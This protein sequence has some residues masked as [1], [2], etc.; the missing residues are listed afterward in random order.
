MLPVELFAAPT[1]PV[2]ELPLILD[3]A[4]APGGKTTHLVS[5][6]KDCALVLAND[7]SAGRLPALCA[8]LQ[9]WGAINAAVTC[10]PGERFGT[11][12]PETFDRVL[13]DAPCSMEHL[14][15]GE[16]QPHRPISSRERQGLA[17]R[18]LRLLVSAFQALKTGG[19]LV[20]ATCTLAPEEDEA[21]LDGLLRLYSGRVVVEDCSSHLNQ[22]APALSEYQ[23][24]TFDP[25]VQRAARLWPHLF[26]T[27]GFFTAL[28]TKTGPVD[29]NLQTPP[30][31]PFASSGFSPL[32]PREV[33]SLFGL[34]ASA[35][36]FDLESL[37]T[38]EHLSLWRRGAGVFALP[39]TFLARIPGLPWISLGL[40]MGDETPDG[41]ILSH[42]WAARFGSQFTQG[43]YSLPE[44]LLPSWLAGEDLRGLPHPESSQK[45]AYIVKDAAGRNLGRGR[46]AGD[47]LRNLL[48]KK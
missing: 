41:F 17:Q 13:L 42:A 1:P 33:S 25:S 46:F 12:F 19:Q 10:F 39:E 6:W 22:P 48:P 45:I 30:G 47:R 9:D 34:F 32:A 43:G 4:A 37:L 44:E 2:N 40:P 36:G 15:P 7:S 28:L 16:P 11:W 18:Q 14:R 35:Y 24:Q 26:N 8:A 29:V 38:E 21:V 5:R 3:L 27:S 20:Y 23:G 31:R